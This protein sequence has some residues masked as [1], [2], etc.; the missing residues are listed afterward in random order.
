V[1]DQPGCSG[2]TARLP[3][4]PGSQTLTPPSSAKAAFGGEATAA[5]ANAKKPSFDLIAHVDAACRRRAID[6]RMIVPK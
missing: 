1:R 4:K 5:N 2:A 3:K 6:P